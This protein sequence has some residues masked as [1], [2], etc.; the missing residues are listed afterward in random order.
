[1]RAVLIGLVALVKCLEAEGRSDVIIFRQDASKIYSMISAMVWLGEVH[2]VLM[3]IIAT[4]ALILTC[5]LCSWAGYRLGK[6][7]SLQMTVPQQALAPAMQPPS[8]IVIRTR[9]MATQSQATYKRWWA[10]SEF[11][12]LHEQQHGAWED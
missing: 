11:R 2:F 4:I 6:T 1:M 7:T 8:S 12:A 9:N 3:I 5:C 10:K